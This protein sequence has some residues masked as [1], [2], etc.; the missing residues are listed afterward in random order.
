M[1]YKFLKMAFVI[2]VLSVFV[3]IYQHNCLIR[4]SYKKQRLQQKELE[5]LKRKSE[6]LTQLYQ[7]SDKDGVKKWAGVNHGMSALSF[8][9]IISV[10]GR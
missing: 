5:Y 2:L 3:K 9:Q 8:S 1:K 6:L 7:A 10:T 4:M